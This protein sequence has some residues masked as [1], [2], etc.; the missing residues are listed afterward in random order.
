MS[1]RARV[2]WGMARVAVVLVGAAVV[3]TRTTHAN[4]VT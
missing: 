3:V 1:L 2:L 4:L